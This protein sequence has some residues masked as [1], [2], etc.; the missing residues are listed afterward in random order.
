MC[1]IIIIFNATAKHCK[2]IRSFTS[3]YSGKIK[4]KL[5]FFLYFFQNM[6]KSM[7]RKRVQEL[8][9][10]TILSTMQYFTI[11]CYK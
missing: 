5:F 11:K 1:V 6:K 2:L 9:K 7:Q 3:P 8:G 4:V 10:P